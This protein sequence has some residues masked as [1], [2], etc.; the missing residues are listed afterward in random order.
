MA[1]APPSSI[2]GTAR[3]GRLTKKLVARLRPGDVAVIDHLRVEAE[4]FLSLSGLPEP[5]TSFDGRD[6][7][8]VARGGDYLRDLGK[9]TGYIARRDPVLVGS[10]AARTPS[11]TAVSSRT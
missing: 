11:S 9:L 6:A 10:T 1:I 3:V 4:G 8:V 2:T 7:L 5:R